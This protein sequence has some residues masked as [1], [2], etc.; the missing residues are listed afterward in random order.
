MKNTLFAIALATAGL[1]AIP[2]TS[3][4]AENQSGFFINGNIGQ[5]NLDKG[6]YDDDDTGFGA[7]VGYRWAVTPSVLL[8]V[9]GGYTD[10]GEFSAKSRYDGLGV[11]SAELNRTRRVPHA[12]S[13]RRRPR[14]PSCRRRRASA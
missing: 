10:L 7:N 5:S 13:A 2:L 6:V 1:A 3:Q 4:A 8:G 12:R 14:G 11:R 9:E